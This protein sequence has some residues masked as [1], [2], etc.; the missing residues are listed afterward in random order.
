MMRWIYLSGLG[1]AIYTVKSSVTSP[2]NWRLGNFASALN[3]LIKYI[4]VN[5]YNLRL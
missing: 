2:A 1:G 3:S 4:L 5:C